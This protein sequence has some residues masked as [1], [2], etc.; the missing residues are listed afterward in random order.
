VNLFTMYLL[1]LLYPTFFISKTLV[2]STAI[3]FSICK[4]YNKPFFN[5]ELY[6]HEYLLDKM[7]IVKTVT[8]DV[9]LHYN[10]VYF[11]LSRYHLHDQDDGIFFRTLQTV[12]FIL[13]LECI[14]YVFHRLSHVVPYL[15]N[16]KHNLHHKNRRIYPIDFLEFDKIDNVAQTLYINLPLVIA[17]MNW[18][19][20]AMVYY[21][22]TVGAYLIHSDIFTM[23]HIIH[24]KKYKKNYSILIPLMDILCG[25]YE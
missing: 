23:T 11:T 17:P 15:Y 22:Y 21:I 12:K 19:D 5:P 1:T 8:T 7:E 9:I 14:G 24:H 25:T 4:L 18:N 2:L 3:A 10:I 20:Y 6:C 13:L 16:K